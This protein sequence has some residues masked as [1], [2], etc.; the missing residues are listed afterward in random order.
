MPGI[1]RTAQ[2]VINGCCRPEL[3]TGEDTFPLEFFAVMRELS[4][5]RR[6]ERGILSVRSA[7]HLIATTACGTV[8]RE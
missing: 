3:N 6:A 2:S 4:V 1:K 5:C 7:F 8:L